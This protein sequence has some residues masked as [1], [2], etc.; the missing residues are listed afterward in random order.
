TSVMRRDAAADDRVP[1]TMVANLGVLLDEAAHEIPARFTTII[2]GCATAEC[3]FRCSF[4][5]APAG[6]QKH[7]CR[8]QIVRTKRRQQSRRRHFRQ[9]KF[10]LWSAGIFACGSPA[11]LPVVASIKSASRDAC[12]PPTR[13][14]AIPQAFPAGEVSWLLRNRLRWQ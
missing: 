4:I 8:Q 14:S 9:A 6:R 2:F 13:I 10:H 7:D 5:A 11:S 1:M 3:C 12:D